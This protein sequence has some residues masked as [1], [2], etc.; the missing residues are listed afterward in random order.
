VVGPWSSRYVTI[1]TEAPATPVLSSPADAS[2]T[3]SP[4]PSFSW[5]ASDGASGYEMQ[6]DITDPPL[7]T[8]SNSSVRSFKPPS[9]L[10]TRTYYWRVRAFDLAGNVSDWSA[11]FSLVVDSAPRVAPISN[12]YTTHMPTLTWGRTSWATEYEVVVDNNSNFRSPEFNTTVSGLEQAITTGHLD[13][14]TYYWRVR[15]RRPDD[16]WGPWS[17][18]EQ[19]A[20]DVP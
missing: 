17:S 18:S 8:V 1:D 4:Q 15:A 19:F 20:V 12:R 13:N 3:T 9:V 16:R 2:T 6:L 11:T 7:A 14:G 10:L 5:T